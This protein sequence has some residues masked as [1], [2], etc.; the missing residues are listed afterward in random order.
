MEYYF[1]GMKHYFEGTKYYFEGMQWQFS[2]V[3]LLF[4]FSSNFPLRLPCD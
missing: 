4:L 2:T 1:D 3:F